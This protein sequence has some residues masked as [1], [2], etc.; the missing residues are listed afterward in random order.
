MQKAPSPPSLAGQRQRP[1]IRGKESPSRSDADD[2]GF[3]LVQYGKRKQKKT[4]QPAPS[5]P[6][7][8][9]TPPPRAGSKQPDS[10]RASAAG[11][12][13]PQVTVL[14][15]P[16]TQSASLRRLSRFDLSEELN[17]FGA[18]AK[19]ASTR[20]YPASREGRTR[21]VLRGIDAAVEAEE[22]IARIKPQVP[23]I[24]GSRNGQLLFITFLGRQPPTHVHL[25]H[26][27]VPVE[28]LTARN[29]QCGHCYRFG[30][31]RTTCRSAARCARCA[32]AHPT[33]DCAAPGLRCC[34][35]GGTHW[36]TATTCPARL[37]AVNTTQAPPP[38][39]RNLPPPPPPA[40]RERPA[41]PPSSEGPTYASRL[42]AP[43][44]SAALLGEALQTI[45]HLTSYIEHLEHGN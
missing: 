28:I 15:K 41:S 37:T 38:R 32:G 31:I 12:L 17:T 11:R 27:R 14:F 8:Q 33:Q 7:P 40:V 6:L 16:T 45:K 26:I 44:P 39:K 5:P 10:Q 22:L 23:I 30:H 43:A 18:W 20:P 19:Y 3:T 1:K 34:N 21:A 2:V 24:G 42:R 36:A 9:A 35:C 29:L 25:S 13:T 4:S